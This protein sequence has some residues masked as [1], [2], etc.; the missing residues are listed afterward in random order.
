[1]GQFAGAIEYEEWYGGY[2]FGEDVVGVNVYIEF[3]P[4]FR[5]L[6]EEEAHNEHEVHGDDEGVEVLVI[7]HD[8]DQQHWEVDDA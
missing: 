4:S 7:D 3:H 6:V 5:E 8:S 2:E 1:M